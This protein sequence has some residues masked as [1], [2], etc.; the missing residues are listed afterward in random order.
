[1]PPA[2][3]T[4][5]ITSGNGKCSARGILFRTVKMLT[6][7]DQGGK[8]TQKSTIGFYKYKASAPISQANLPNFSNFVNYVKMLCKYHYVNSVNNRSALSYRV[9]I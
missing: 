2:K 4:D 6:P 8:G 1:M 9:K 7:S 5:K 3:H